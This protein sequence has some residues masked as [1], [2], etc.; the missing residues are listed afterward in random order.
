MKRVVAI[1]IIVVLALSL[2]ALASQGTASSGNVSTA[3]AGSV[4]SLESEQQYAEGVVEIRLG[5]TVVADGK[6]VAVEGDT[7]SITAAGIYRISGTLTGGTMDVNTKGKVYL[8]LDGANVI[9]DSGPALSIT[10]AKKVTLT[11]VEGTENHLSDAENDPKSEAVLLTNDTLLINGKG[12]LVVTGNNLEGISSDDDLIINS[13][14][15]RITAVDDGVNA[16]DDITVN[17]G[18]TYIL[19][20]GDGLDSNGTINVNGG[21]L[22][23]LGGMADGD[24]GL[25]AIGAFTITG[26]T[27]IAGGNAMANPGGNSTQSSIYVGTGKAQAAGTLVRIQR[28]QEKILTFAPAGPYSSILF[29]SSDLVASDNYQISIGGTCNE[30]A[31]D[32]LYSKSASV[33]TAADTVFTVIAG[34]APEQKTGGF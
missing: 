27:L 4:A 22:I 1:V 9:S 10:D 17:G 2:A 24:G 18:Y 11:L 34:T 19:A 31:I 28:D 12:T 20:G 23:S 8:E 29:S 3:Q 26:G 5:S 13:G 25:D 15:V 30:T 21:T 6:G 32:G 7:V 14:T 33:T 16:H